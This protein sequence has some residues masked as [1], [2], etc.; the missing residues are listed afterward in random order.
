MLCD[1]GEKAP[2][3]HIE[4]TCHLI[5]DLKLDMTQKAQYVALGHLT[6]VPTYM[7]YSS[8][9]NCDTVRIGFTMDALNNL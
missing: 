4:I 9:V 2:V 5:F 3:R 8:V 6:D 1:K 7:T